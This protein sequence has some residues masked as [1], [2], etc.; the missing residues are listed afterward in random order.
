LINEKNP[1]GKNSI[2]QQSLPNGT[3]VQYRVDETRKHLRADEFELPVVSH[4]ARDLPK[5]ILVA[6]CPL[7]VLKITE[8]LAFRLI[9][10]ESQA[11]NG[12]LPDLSAIRLSFR[13]SR[14]P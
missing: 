7:P 6:R 10:R 11:R 5:E 2:N 8:I 3:F 4:M 1:V 9:R 14:L 12:N 13:L